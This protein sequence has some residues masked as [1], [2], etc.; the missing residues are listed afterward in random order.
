MSR[1][2]SSN[3]SLEHLVDTPLEGLTLEKI[4][5]NVEDNEIWNEDKEEVERIKDKVEKDYLNYYAALHSDESCYSIAKKLGLWK[6]TVKGWKKKG[7]VPKS[8]VPYLRSFFPQTA[9][10]KK[11]FAYFLGAIT[12]GYYSPT[13]EDMRAIS[14]TFSDP[15]LQTKFCRKVK[16][17][18]GKKPKEYEGIVKI[19]NLKFTH[20]V[21]YVMRDRECFQRI[22]DNN[23]TRKELLVGAIETSAITPVKYNDSYGLILTLK[24]EDKQLRYLEVM[25]GLK[26][27]PSILRGNTIA[28]I[29]IPNLERM[30]E[31][32]LP[33]TSRDQ[34]L[35][36]SFLDRET[37]AKDFS[38]DFYYSV[39]QEAQA[40][41]TRGELNYKRLARDY[42]LNE[43]TVHGWIKKKREPF[44]VTRYKIL[45]DVLGLENEYEM[46]EPADSL[47]LAHAYEVT[48]ITEINEPTEILGSWL[49][50]VDGVEY[51]LLP[52]MQEEYT[53]SYGIDYFTEEDAVFICSE[54]RRS[55]AERDLE[56]NFDTDNKITRINVK[57]NNDGFI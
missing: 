37:T 34:Q 9:K 27:Y 11:D 32:D 13:K 36:R 15:L 53:A 7:R 43:K 6:A 46:T 56:I 35:I 50:P 49:L 17:I 12:Y 14:K 10:E 20:F 31:L 28:I 30:L 55:A 19:Q 25:F 5:Q 21:S 3:E 42:G 24:D 26:I 18:L 2:K 39:L 22:V 54:L 8:C 4:L 16:Q 1:V 48:E 40:R 23:Q 41:K 44:T 29:G 38:V 33:P 47:D 45:L 51:E 57:D 52:K